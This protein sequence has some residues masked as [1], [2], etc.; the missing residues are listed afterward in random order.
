MNSVMVES[1][2]ALSRKETRKIRIYL[3]DLWSFIPYYVAHLMKGLQ[4]ARCNVILGSSKYHLDRQYF[5]K[6]GLSTDRLLLDSGGRLRS[7]ALRRIVKSIEYVVNM[8]V[9]ALRFAMSRPNIV[10][11]QYLPFLERGFSF[12]VWFLKW[13]HVLSIPIVYTVHNITRQDKP[14]ENKTLYR[15]AYQ[16]ADALICHGDEARS[17]LNKDFGVEA[18]KI[19]LIPHGPLF[20]E[21][22]NVSVREARSILGLPT[23]EVLVLSVGVISGYKGIPFLLEAW[24]KL[25]RSGT[26]AQL[27]I[28]GTGDPH[29]LNEISNIV[30]REALNSSVHLWLRFI[31]VENLPLLYQAA[32]I[33]VY[34]YKAGTTSGALL[35]GLNYGKAIVATRLPFFCEYLTDRKTALL[36]EYGAAESL[37]SALR[38]LIEQPQERFRIARALETQTSQGTSWQEIGDATRGCYD[39]LLVAKIRC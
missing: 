38:T 22:P 39:S 36:V 33:L 13:M 29:L 18:E 8:L 5:G 11:V 4:N 10:H 1:N 32:D 27:L 9:L 25:A 30:S 24:K 3:M 34:P 12:E 15:R 35:A 7:S 19:F 2:A 28:A 26:K 6:L 14:H 20:H 31:P 16:I 37:T 21:L 17:Q 23:E